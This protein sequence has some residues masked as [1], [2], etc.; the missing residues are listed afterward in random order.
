ME[1][2]NRTWKIKNEIAFSQV[3]SQNYLVSGWSGT[4][5]WGTWSIEEKPAVFIPAVIAGEKSTL[6][7]EVKAF[8]PNSFNFLNVDVS[9]NGNEPTLHSLGREEFFI[10]ISDTPKLYR[11]VPGFMIEFDILNYDGIEEFKNYTNIEDERKL[12]IGLVKISKSNTTN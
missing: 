10:E 11:G 8:V 3:E 6:H 4:E 5:E 12:G 9:V 7:I 2:L 1:Q